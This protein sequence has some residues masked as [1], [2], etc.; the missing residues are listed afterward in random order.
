M[1][2]NTPSPS[3]PA[4]AAAATPSVDASRRK[5]LGAAAA[6]ALMSLVDPALRAGAWAQVPTRRKRRK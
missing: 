5:L 2:S 3:A 6:G 4:A 1:K